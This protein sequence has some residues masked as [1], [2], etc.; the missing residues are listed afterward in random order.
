MSMWSYIIIIFHHISLLSSDVRSFSHDYRLF[1]YLFWEVP[2]KYS[3][4]IL[5]RSFVSFLIDCKSSLHNVSYLSVT[6][7]MKIFQTMTCLFIFFT[8]YDW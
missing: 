1:E 5:I 2:V 7:I 8:M 3:A 4:N 6:Y